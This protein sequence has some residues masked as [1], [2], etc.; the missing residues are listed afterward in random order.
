MSQHNFFRHS[1]AYPGRLLLVSL[2]SN[3]LF[4]PDVFVGLQARSTALKYADLN[5]KVMEDSIKSNVL[6]S[7]YSVLIA[8]KRQ[9]YIIEGIERLEKLHSDQEKL[10]KNGFAEKLDIDKTQVSL[11]NLQTTKTQLDNLIYIGYASLKYA[12][13]LTQK[14]TLNLTDTLIFRSSKKGPA[15]WFRIQ[16]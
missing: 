16:I 8:E 15:G 5:V 2:F 4:Q 12:L 1:L 11:N 10:Y 7:Y 14:D 6:R 9:V 13:G 3:C